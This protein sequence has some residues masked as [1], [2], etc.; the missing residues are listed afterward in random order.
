MILAATWNDW[1]KE[2]EMIGVLLLGRLLKKLNVTW[3]MLIEC[4]IAQFL[5]MFSNNLTQNGSGEEFESKPKIE[6]QI[7]RWVF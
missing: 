4:Q 1:R 6:I 2:V 5:I 3:I 7:H